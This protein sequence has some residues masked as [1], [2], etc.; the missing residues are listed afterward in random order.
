MGFR[1]KQVGLEWLRLRSERG[2]DV[3]TRGKR[4]RRSRSRRRRRNWRK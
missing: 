4:R 3:E 1:R 2:S